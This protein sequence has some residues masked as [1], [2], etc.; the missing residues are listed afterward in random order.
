MKQNAVVNI[1]TVIE[2]TQYGLSL[3]SEENGDI[4]IV[5]MKDIQDGQVNLKPSARITLS[6]SDLE[7]YAL[8]KGDILLNRTNSPDLVGKAAIVDEDTNVV[9]ASY[10][11]RLK[12]DRKS[13]SPEYLNYWINSNRGQKQI[14]ALATRAVSQANI[15]PTTFCNHFYLPM[16]SLDAQQYFAAVLKTWDDAIT[17]VTAT[18]ALLQQRKQGLMQQLLTGRRRLKGF[19]GKW[20]AVSIGSFATHASNINKSGRALPV[21]SCTK[22]AGLVD[23]LS[24]FGKQIFSQ[25]TSTYK[26][27][28]RGQFAYATNHIEEGSIG[29]Q[30]LYDAALISPMY[31]VFEVDAAAVDHG[32]LHKLLK[33]EAMR[34]VFESSTHGSVARRGSLRWPEFAKLRIAVPP[35][36]EQTAIA[37]LLGVATEEIDL[38]SAEIAQLRTQKRALMQKL[39][40]GNWHMPKTALP[41]EFSA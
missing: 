28:A 33:T 12:V 25:N 19:K 37:S 31:T 40:S 10:L 26:L 38:V 1:G 41:K 29:Y 13:A 22:Y 39:L 36:P 15:N 30:G 35:L 34:R 2:S 11:V 8:R 20:K 6:S 17:N 32:F 9:F 3:P 23:S 4:S 7:R 5:G 21:L 16:P 24:Y 18:F 14:K 27:V